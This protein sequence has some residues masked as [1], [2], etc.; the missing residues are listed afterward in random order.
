MIVMTNGLLR[1]RCGRRCCPHQTNVTA[2]HPAT[3]RTA[4]APV[5][6]RLR[7]HKLQ[8][9]PNPERERERG[10]QLSYDYIPT[11]ARTGGSLLA[12]LAPAPAFPLHFVSV[13]GGWPRLAQVPASVLA[14]V[15][16]PSLRSRPRLDST[17]HRLA[18]RQ[19]SYRAH[20]V[21]SSIG[22][23]IS[24]V[25]PLRGAVDQSQPGR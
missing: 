12:E 1:T 9:N 5:S 3:A 10:A 4:P 8:H 13:C 14:R 6:E 11:G 18:A 17:Q 22:L 24:N 15:R 23:C 2:Q 21:I 19:Y 25:W 20:T 7:A 16:H